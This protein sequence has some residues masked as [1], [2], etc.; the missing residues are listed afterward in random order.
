MKLLHQHSTVSAG[1]VFL[2]SRVEKKKMMPT[3]SFSSVLLAHWS[4]PWLLMVLQ[5]PD[6]ELMWITKERKC[7]TKTEET[8]EV[9]LDALKL[10][11]DD[12]M[13]ED[14]SLVLT[15]RELPSFSVA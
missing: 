5:F 7:S 6:L 1:L 14:C 8:S 11:N 9:S 12:G 4:F 13:D 3:G 15:I 10:Q 2:C